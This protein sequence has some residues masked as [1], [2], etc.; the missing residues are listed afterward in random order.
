MKKLLFL[1]VFLP[2]IS[3]AQ[4][5]IKIDSVWCNKKVKQIST[6]NV[7]F[8]IKQVAEEILS[9]KYNLCDSNATSVKIEVTRIG[10]PSSTFKIGGVGEAT[11][12]TQ[13]Y[14][15][16]YFGD[17]TIDGMGESETRAGFVLIELTDGKVPFNNTTIGTAIKK[18][19]LNA[20][21]KL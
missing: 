14:I 16:L 3:L 13:V 19:I 12:I 7:L 9:E 18:A 15:K 20:S 11:Q 10:M 4:N 8:G 5:C 6:R 21:E 1:L 17:K 2:T